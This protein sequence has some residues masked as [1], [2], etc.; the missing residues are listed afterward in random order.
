MGMIFGQQ[1]KVDWKLLNCQRCL[2]VIANDEKEN[3]TQIHHDDKVGDQVLIVENPYE[4]VKKPKHL[5]PTQGPY[6]IIHVHMNGTLYICGVTYA[7]D[8]S[9]HCLC[10]YNP[11]DKIHK[12]HS[13]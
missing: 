10:P 11:C 6:E 4:L 12:L 1:V 9:I 8:I 2:Q 13:M 3:K 5:L 7:K